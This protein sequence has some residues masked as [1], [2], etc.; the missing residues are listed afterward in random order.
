MVNF[1][2]IMNEHSFMGGVMSSHTSGDKYEQIMTAAEHLIAKVGIH[3]FSMKKLACEA[4]VAAG[5]IYCY[6]SDKEHL[7]EEVRL[8]VAKRLADATQKNLHEGM[9]LKE[10]YRSIWLNIWHFAHSN[11]DIMSNRVQY[12]S[13]PYNQRQ[14]T[15]DLEKKMFVEIGQLFNQGKEEGIFPPLDNE[16]LSGLSFEVSITLAR[17]HALGFYQLNDDAL[18]AIIEASWNAI[19]KH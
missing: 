18:E 11:L 15:R 5:T 16:I 13:L 3:G 6:F 7:L 8:A 17:K 14:S 1:Q 10:R 19:I 12:Q 2:A 9:S 4:G